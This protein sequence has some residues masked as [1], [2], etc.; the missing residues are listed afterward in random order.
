L[1]FVGPL[2]F[3]V[4][5]WMVIIGNDCAGFFA[6]VRKILCGSPKSSSFETLHGPGISPVGM[7]LIWRD[8]KA[9][10]P[11]YSIKG[12][13]IAFN[14]KAT[15]QN[16]AYLNFSLQQTVGIQF[17][18]SDRWDLRTGL[19]DFHFSDAFMVPSNPG[20]DEMAYSAGL[21]FRVGK[22]KSN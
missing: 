17:R 1:G 9:W 21:T 19:D 22:R 3:I 18:L 2:F 7:R 16:A 12:G 13:L 14:K 20:I 4:R 8:G 5:E 15:S 11:Y 6:P 10:K